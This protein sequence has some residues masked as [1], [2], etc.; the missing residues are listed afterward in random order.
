MQVDIN[1]AEYQPLMGSSYIPPTKTT[2]HK[3]S[4]SECAE[5]R[6]QMFLWIVLTALHQADRDGERSSKYAAYQYEL[7]TTGI[8]FL[9]TVSQIFKFEKLNNISINV[10]DL[11]KR[12]TNYTLVR[13]KK[14]LPS[15]YCSSQRG[16]I[17][18]IVG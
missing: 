8:K 1:R 14:I 7:N 11:K 17:N 2:D 12:S 4:H 3:E 5:Q 10:L 13:K 15:T 9:T 16:N 18:I 6:R